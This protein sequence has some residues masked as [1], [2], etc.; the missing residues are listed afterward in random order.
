MKIFLNVSYRKNVKVSK[1]NV[2]F[3]NTQIDV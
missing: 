3:L 2:K 1:F